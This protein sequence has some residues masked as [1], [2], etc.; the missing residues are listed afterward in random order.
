[1]EETGSLR[2]LRPS[3]LRTECDDD[4]A[5]MIFMLITLRLCIGQVLVLT[6]GRR[7]LWDR[8]T[9]PPPQYLDWGT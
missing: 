7:S 1:M 5:I 8:G 3:A 2:D 4:N 6:Q 9:R